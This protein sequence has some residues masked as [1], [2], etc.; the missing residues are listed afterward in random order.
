MPR[1]RLR[2]ES[3][4]IGTS[5]DERAGKPV[6]RPLAQSAFATRFRRCAGI[7]V[8]LGLSFLS[9]CVPA[10]GTVSLASYLRQDGT[11]LDLR[12]TDADDEDLAGLRG[13]AF[14]R[15]VS[16]LLART[17]VGDR[18]LGLLRSLRLREL[19][20]YLTAVTDSGMEHLRGLPLERLD[21]TG[22]AVGDSGL[23]HLR[24]MPLAI[25]V[26]RETRVTD[27][28]LGFLRGLPLRYV[29]LSHT[30]ITDAGLI[31]LEGLRELGTADLSNTAI[32]DQ[33]V[34]VLARIPSLT[35]I[36][37]A[38][39]RITAAGLATIRT[40]RPEVRVH[41]DRPVR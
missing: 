39:T 34:G 30:A 40:A 35:T 28:G 5:Q 19:D 4:L 26:L 15:V 37:V 33:G 31:H 9:A 11:Q 36:Y 16:V 2:A 27:A 17:K 6:P 25:L 14:S 29:D 12:G 1:G 23:A 3:V 38:G 32:S 20:L 18:G 21:L 8:A 13:P 22:T 24:G 10:Q 41:A 7:A